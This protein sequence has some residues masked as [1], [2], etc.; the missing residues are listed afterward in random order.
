MD[1]QKSPRSSRDNVR[2]SEI[3]PISF[4]VICMFFVAV[5][6]VYRIIVESQS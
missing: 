4:L 2:K 3:S 1:L 6:S 5:L